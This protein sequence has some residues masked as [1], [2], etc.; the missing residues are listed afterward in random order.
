[1]DADK[2]RFARAVAAGLLAAALPCAAQD[3]PAKPILMVMP[4]QAGSAVDV[5]MRIVAQKMSDNMGA[6]SWSR[7]SRR[8]EPD[9]CRAGEAGDTRHT[10]GA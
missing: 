2:R 5:M 7:T 10:L 6:R 8:T 9:R 4:L 1:M 3:Y